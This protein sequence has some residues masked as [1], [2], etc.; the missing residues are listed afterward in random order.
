MKNLKAIILAGGEGNRMKSKKPKVLHQILNTTMID[1][2]IQE[3][4]V[5][6][7]ERVCV[8]VGHKA[9]EVKASISK[10]NKSYNKEKIE[11]ALQKEQKG[12]GHAVMM[13]ENFISDE[14]TILILY[15]DTPLIKGE[16]L[17]FIVSKHQENNCSATLITAILEN[18]TAYGRIVR[19]ADGDFQKIVEEKDASSEEKAI[20]EINTGLYVFQGKALKTALS[21]LTTNNNQGEYYL[22]DCLE[23]I[24][25][26]N[27]K[28][29]VV[30]AD[31]SESFFGVNSRSQLAT[32]SAIMQKRII[33]KHMENG[34]TFIKPE[35]V[36]IEPS[37]EIGMDT[38]I[39][40][41]CILE[42]DTKIGED[43]FIGAYSHL[44]NMTL[45]DN[46]QIQH[47]T[48]TKSSIDSHAVIG[49]YAYIRPDCTI[50]H[51]AKVGDFVEVKNSKIGAYTKVPHL[52]Y[53]GDTD[54]GEKVNF[55][56]GSIMVNYDGKKKHR[57]TIE[58]GCF[59]G[60]NSNLVS[61]VHIGENAYI[62]AGSTITK[63][64]SANV[65]ALARAKDQVEKIKK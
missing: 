47:S 64:V 27:L 3:S 50:G 15:G 49:P 38:T 29:S 59:I 9:E 44:S 31:S 34:V 60:C 55:G 4:F 19:D 10:S 14:D 16:D 22:T 20:K 46:I 23:L 25:K 39:H 35:S 13:A 51:H 48:A 11:F 58:D 33:E 43:C 56:C 12:T 65:L 41:G 37:V 30:T 6:Q 26:A 61:P 36:Y 52:S 24:L 1:Y 45:A 28:V 53:V 32:A 5:A 7:A 63:D 18:P 40:M 2:V 21:Q 54:A 62:A 8:I 17:A 57:S 42:G